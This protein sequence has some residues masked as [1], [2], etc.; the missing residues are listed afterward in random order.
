MRQPQEIKLKQA[1]YLRLTS[2]VK[3]KSSSCKS[4]ERACIILLAQQQVS[5]IHIAILLKISRQKVARWRGRFIELG[6]ESIGK[7]ATRPGRM[8]ELDDQ[9]VRQVLHIT[10]NN[11]LPSGK[12]MTQKNV[13]ELCGI[14]SSSV[15]RIWQKNGVSTKKIAGK[16]LKVLS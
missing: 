9:V 6:M 5:N 2:I 8:D 11:M 12:F 1:E 15:G 7:D 13:A 10:L 3:R 16:K 4:V 14:S